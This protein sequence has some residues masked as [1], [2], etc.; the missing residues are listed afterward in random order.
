MG[1]S[2]FLSFDKNFN[3]ANHFTELADSS[4]T[5]N[6]ALKKGN[7]CISL[8]HLNGNIYLKNTLYIV[9]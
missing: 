9:I 5:S 8:V 1:E 3:S 2:K 4:K 6:I 7:I